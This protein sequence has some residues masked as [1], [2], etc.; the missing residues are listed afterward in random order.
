MSFEDVKDYK[1]L[2]NSG[3]KCCNGGRWKPSVQK[4]E[5]DILKRT[6]RNKRKLDRHKYRPG[7]TSN[8]S[9]YERGK[10]RNIKA[11]RIDD[12]QVYKSFSKYAL[13]PN[14]ESRIIQ[15]NTA[16]QPGK[17]T[18][19]AILS[20][21]EGLTK[22]TRKWKN[23]FY[24]ITWDYHDY[25]NSIPHE[26]IIDSIVF[27][28]EYLNNL[29][30]DYVNVFNG[31]RGIGIG[32]EPSQNISI[33]YPSKLDR[34]LMLDNR[35][36]DS[37]RYMDDGY[38]ICYLKEEARAILQSIRTISEDLG[39]ILNEKRTRIYWMKTDYVIWLKKKTHI[40]ETGKIYMELVNDN[41]RDEIRRIDYQKKM[42][43]SGI[44]PRIIADISIQC[45]CAYAK[46]YNSYNKMWR[47]VSYYAETFNVPWSRAKLLLRKNNKKWINE[48][49]MD[50][51]RKQFYEGE[52]VLNGE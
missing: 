4:Y 24:V 2:L 10:K 29:L 11:H 44:M 7:K 46:N 23:D 40:T 17:G 27:D 34:F 22:A 21:K 42:I 36:I 33:V 35:V 37:G 8:F 39:L 16:S 15:N 52:E 6:S 20:F 26:Q 48:S 47:V 5:L 18:E 49:N 31:D 45:W 19:Q 13:I 51:E 32:G 30:C 28:D 1:N 38:A 9:I 14:I 41:V 25:F 43:D 50:E 3:K 12:R